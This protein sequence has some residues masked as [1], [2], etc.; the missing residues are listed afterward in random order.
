LDTITRKTIAGLTLLVLVLNL[1]MTGKSVQRDPSIQTFW[2]KFKA[3][4]IKGDKAAVA[5]MSQFPIELEYGVPSVKTS[6]QLIKRYREVFNGE[7]NAA[8]CFAESKPE[9]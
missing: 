3:A 9:V 4:V 7:T 6:A 2:T 1:S 5:Q 8:K